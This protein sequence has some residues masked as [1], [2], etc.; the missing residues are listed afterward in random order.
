MSLT[1][2]HKLSETSK[3]SPFFTDALLLS[4][5]DA[6]FLINPFTSPFCFL[7]L[8]ICVAISTAALAASAPGINEAANLPADFA[9]PPSQPFPC[10]SKFAS[11]N[12]MYS[13]N[14]FMY[15]PIEMKGISPYLVINLSSQSFFS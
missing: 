15:H 11:L 5:K 8:Y 4:G 1:A 2:F 6:A 9:I 14:V 12:S 13:L 3:I 10:W 7:I